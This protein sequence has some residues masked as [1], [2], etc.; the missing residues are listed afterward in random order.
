MCDTRRFVQRFSEDWTNLDPESFGKWWHS[1]GTV[2][3]PGM[4]RPISGPNEEPG[5]VARLKS[6]MP[7]FR[8]EVTS[9]GAHESDVFIEW[10]VNATM[11]GK[12]LEWSGVTHFVLQ[13]D[14]AMKAVAYFDT[15]P[16][17]AAVDPAMVRPPLL[18]VSGVQA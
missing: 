5:V 2:F 12:K 15:Q 8:Q 11:A 1:T 7:D 4:T 13:N 14:E 3:W 10:K 18:S 6:T 9:W 16:L 17:W